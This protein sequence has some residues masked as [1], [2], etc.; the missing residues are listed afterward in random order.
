MEARGHTVLRYAIRCSPGSLVEGE[1]IAELDRTR[2]MLT[3]G[4]GQLIS[5]MTRSLAT[6][7]QRAVRAAR[8]AAR[9]SSVSTRGMLVHLAY[10]AEALVLADWCRRDE[11]EHIHVHFGTNPA[12]VGALVHHLT[13]IPFSMTVH[14]PEEFD[15]PVEHG[16]GTKIASSSF[17][18]AISSYGRSQLMRWAAP[19]DWQKLKVVH[20]GVDASYLAEPAPKTASNTLLCIGRYSEQKGH[21]LLIEAAAMLRDRKL[22][23][24]VRLAGDG[25][26]RPEMEK[27]V[28]DHGLEDH[29]LLLGALPQPRIRDEITSARAVVLPS[30]A[31]GLPVALMEA[32]ALRTPVISTYVAGIPELVTPEHG[33]LVPA[34]DSRALT[35]AMQ[36]AL[37]ADN[38]V[39]D[40]MGVAAR[41]RVLARHDI[42]ASASLLE[43]HIARS[44]SREGA[45]SLSSGAPVGNPIG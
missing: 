28:R 1:D 13:G 41:E 10:F 44:A 9:Y 39:L 17:V 20:C 37:D 32:M 2:H 18:A 19:E 23:F 27:R 14:G 30:F 24:Q 11:V 35:D 12:T 7:P 16:L 43:R 45:R 6:G 15:R 33:W 3:T 36:Q 34:G 40:R 4:Y 31:E 25:P 42:A 21:L 38:A 8:E 5:A 22:D 26:L 29:V